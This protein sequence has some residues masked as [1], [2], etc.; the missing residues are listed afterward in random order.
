MR[1]TVT[2]AELLAA[3]GASVAATGLTARAWIW[4]RDRRAT[5]SESAAAEA[6]TAHDQ[7]DDADRARIAHLELAL[8]EQRRQLSA[9]VALRL[10]DRESCDRQLDAAREENAHRLAVA[11][12]E[13]GQQIAGVE[14]RHDRIVE[15]LM[16]SLVRSGAVRADDTGVHHVED[17]IRRGRLRRTT[18]PEWPAQPAGAPTTYRPTDEDTDR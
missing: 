12:A 14:A 4:Y 3:S 5:A 10:D 2:I 17:E 1:G 8:D 7:R 11:K 6:R 9:L 15:E 13:C 18:P 16:R